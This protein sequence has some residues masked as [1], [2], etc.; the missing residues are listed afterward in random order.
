MWKP[1]NKG[2]A[3]TTRPGN[4]SS[5]NFKELKYFSQWT[6]SCNQKWS[7]INLVVEIC[8]TVALLKLNVL[9]FFQRYGYN[10]KKPFSDQTS[11]AP[12][13][14]N[15]KIQKPPLSIVL[16]KCLP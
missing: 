14:A 5:L 15:F 2:F 3:E 6:V 1:G 7:S 12:S 11:M 9:M 16:Q 13:V 8:D 10:F 4:N